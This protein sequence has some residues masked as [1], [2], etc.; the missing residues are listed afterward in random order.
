MDE[1]GINQAAGDVFIMMEWQS[2]PFPAVL[3][4]NRLSHRIV[5]RRGKGQ[6]PC[7]ESE[8]MQVSNLGEVWG[9]FKLRGDQKARD[10]LIS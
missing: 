7:P 5:R 8:R 2:S 9:R 4:S 3:T 10:A 1:P 6:N